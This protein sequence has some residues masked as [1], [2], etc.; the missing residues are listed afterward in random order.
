M[1]FNFR[2]EKTKKG[3]DFHL[4]T[5]WISLF[6]RGFMIFYFISDNY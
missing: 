5:V 3:E 6:L 4:F 1:E 2:V